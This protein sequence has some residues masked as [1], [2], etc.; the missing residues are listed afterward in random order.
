VT[1]DVVAIPGGHPTVHKLVLASIG[2]LSNSERKVARTLLS[3]Y[4]S[5]G[6]TTVA[7]L[8]EAAGVS[9]PTVVRF[10]TRIGFAGFPALQRALVR[11]INSELGSPVRQYAQ[12]AATTGSSMLARAQESL[13][14]LLTTSMDEV[15]ESEY[16]A[17]VTALADASRPVQIIGGRFSRM[18]AEYL[19]LHLRLLR[20]D[21]A[22][23]GPE[24]VDRRIALA[25]LRST[26]LLVVYDYRR[27]AQANIEFA[28]RA[29]QRATVALMT[30]NWLSPI[31]RSAKL[32]L[33]VRV[34]WASPFD[35][36]VAALALTESIVASVTERLGDAGLDRL[37]T[38]GE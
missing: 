36:L 3:Q 4:P 25:D 16:D 7:D 31:A 38:L 8:A 17:L 11:E 6:L 26:S 27:Y 30:D 2:D 1:K 22:L 19:A 20:P 12:K 28:E 33:P 29:A 21:V 34:D 35:S 24:D 9:A 5:I 14:D 23:I 37:E 10:T 32:V 13:A 18:A 15:A